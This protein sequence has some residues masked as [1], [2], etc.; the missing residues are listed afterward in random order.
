MKLYKYFHQ[1]IFDTF[2]EEPC[3]RITPSFC[4]NDP[5]EFGITNHDL[6]IY[7]EL[8]EK[9]NL[10]GII[11]LSTSG[12]IPSMWSY[13]SDNNKGFCVEF[14]VDQTNVLASLFYGLDHCD[15]NLYYAKEV[16]YRDKRSYNQPKIF[17][18]TEAQQNLE[19]LYNHYY[20]IKHDSWI[21][22][23]EYRLVLPFVSFN[24]IKVTKSFYEKDNFIKNL[25]INFS[26]DENFY[27]FDRDLIENITFSKWD[28]I[29]K[30]WK[31]S[32]NKGHNILFLK[33]LD[34]LRRHKSP[35]NSFSKI[36]FG[37]NYDMQKFF[38]SIERYRKFEF[39]NSQCTRTTLNP[40]ECPTYLKNLCKIELSLN[41]YEMIDKPIND[42]ISS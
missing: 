22:E 7:P 31:Y 10:H 3:L 30:L 38:N 42:K 34:L 20:F 26:L 4:Q 28:E 23:K 37:L 8:S 18:I 35:R 33:K 40:G 16:T 32:F 5:F 25:K 17:S 39:F 9:I 11:S 2:I 21:S 13:Y 6:L 29:L 36:H 15:K 19:T 14:N 12:V 41:T 1:D 24:I 27:V